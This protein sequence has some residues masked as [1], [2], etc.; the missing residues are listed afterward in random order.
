MQWSGVPLV[1]FLF[2][3]RALVTGLLFHPGG[4][5]E[6]LL[7]AVALYLA[8]MLVAGYFRVRRDK[9]R[10]ALRQARA[11]R[12]QEQHEN[13]DQQAVTDDQQHV[14]KRVEPEQPIY[15]EGER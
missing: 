12:V 3:A 5:E 7:G 1:D 2:S 14:G 9:K 6:W 15:Q 13:S 4:N 10:R 8:V 11:Q